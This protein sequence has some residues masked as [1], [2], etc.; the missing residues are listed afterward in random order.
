MGIVD[1]L[2]VAANA[3]HAD[4]MRWG[5]ASLTPAVKLQSSNASTTATATKATA[6]TAMATIAPMCL[7]RMALAAG[8]RSVVVPAPVGASV[9]TA[10]SEVNGATACA[11]GGRVNSAA[12]FAV[13]APAGD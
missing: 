1:T 10:A 12:S 3:V 6:A 2:T 7:V 11:V 5:S 13:G 9:V 4:T 8:V